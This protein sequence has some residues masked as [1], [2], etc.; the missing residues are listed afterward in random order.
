MGTAP[1]HKTGKGRTASSPKLCT[2][3]EHRFLL[4]QCHIPPCGATVFCYKRP[5][6]EEEGFLLLPFGALLW[7]FGLSAW[8]FAF[9]YWEEALYFGPSG[10]GSFWK[11]K[12][13][14]K[15]KT[16]EGKRVVKGK[17]LKIESLHREL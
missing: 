3:K 13:L 10:V 14:L 11:G 6:K 17:M 7:A 4:L 15:G 1:D 16:A 8:L 2:E 12:E 9:E 5:L